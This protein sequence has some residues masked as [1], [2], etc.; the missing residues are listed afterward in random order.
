VRFVWNI[1]G[2]FVFWGICLY[3][4]T[5][6]E[7]EP[8]ICFFQ[9]LSSPSNFPF[10]GVLS[11]PVLS[12]FSGVLSVLFQVFFLFTIWGSFQVFFFLY[13]IFACHQAINLLT[14]MK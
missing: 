12:C 5:G 14:S 9:F 7:D 3:L 13:W 4:E 6:L 2:S 10:F 1:W 8:N 11:S